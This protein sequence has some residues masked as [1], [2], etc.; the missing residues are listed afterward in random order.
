MSKTK[1]E[2]IDCRMSGEISPR[3]LHTF[4]R[5]LISKGFTF[6][7]TYPSAESIKRSKTFEKIINGDKLI[8]LV[9]DRHDLSCGR[10]IRETSIS[11]FLNSQNLKGHYNVDWKNFPKFYFE[12]YSKTSEMM[13]R[14]H[15]AISGSVQFHFQTC[16]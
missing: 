5:W 2:I 12:N 9:I 3:Q 7:S 4:C 1:K 13:K 16:I 11:L 15:M 8:A 14:D 10:I 6:T